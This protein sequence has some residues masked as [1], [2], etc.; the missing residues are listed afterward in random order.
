MKIKTSLNISTYN[1]LGHI[2]LFF[3]SKFFF[4]ILLCCQAVCCD[5]DMQYIIKLLK[6]INFI[7]FIA[8]LLIYELL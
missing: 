6:I 4:Y 1:N 2:L 7:Y 5:M 3:L 8:S